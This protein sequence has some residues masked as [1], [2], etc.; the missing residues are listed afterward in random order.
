MTNK[1]ALTHVHTHEDQI[2]RPESEA[3]VLTLELCLSK[4]ET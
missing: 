3:S 1:E 2:I 4:Y